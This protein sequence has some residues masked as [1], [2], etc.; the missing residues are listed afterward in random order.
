MRRTLMMVLLLA[1]V[2]SSSLVWFLTA[3]A[4]CGLIKTSLAVFRDIHFHIRNEQTCKVLI[5][6]DDDE[7][8]IMTI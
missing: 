4:F 2:L 7:H 6:Y 3:K 8:D 5:E 1:S